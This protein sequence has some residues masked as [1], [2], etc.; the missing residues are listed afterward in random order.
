M[1]PK[2]EAAWSGSRSW[3]RLAIELLQNGIFLIECHLRL[4]IAVTRLLS[5]ANRKISAVLISSPLVDL[6][7]SQGTLSAQPQALCQPQLGYI[8]R[9]KELAVEFVTV[10]QGV[11]H[12]SSCLPHTAPIGF[13]NVISQLRPFAVPP[14]ARVRAFPVLPTRLERYLI[15]SEVLRLWV[16]VANRALTRQT[17]YRL[18]TA[19]GGGPVGTQVEGYGNLMTIASMVSKHRTIDD[20]PCLVGRRWLGLLLRS[21]SMRGPCWSP[22][23]IS[24]VRIDAVEL[25]RVQSKISMSGQFARLA[26]YMAILRW[27]AQ[28]RMLAEFYCCFLTPNCGS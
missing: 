7:H 24:E 23:R 10:E 15:R 26:E 25:K 28:G 13:S 6:C 18:K 11:F 22:W 4:V 8:Q 3:S 14:E 19:T 27:Q 21:W 9:L 12:S 1:N 20:R 16:A 5:V 17:W 2:V